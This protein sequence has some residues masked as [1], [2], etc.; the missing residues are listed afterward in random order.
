MGNNANVKNKRLK[1]LGSLASVGVLGA[2]LGAAAMIPSSAA[3]AD[4]A[5]TYQATLNP[6][7][8]DAAGAGGTLSLSLSGSQAT[9][10][11]HVNG[12]AATFNGAPY[13]HVQH[14]HINGQDQCPTA[15]ADTNG[16]GVI[17]IPEGKPAYGEI[18]T[19]LSM[20]GST[21]ESAGDDVTVAPSG[22]S[23]T[24]QRTFTINQAT[25]SAI[26]ANKAVIVV[27]GLNPANAPKSSLS[28]PN[29]DGITLPGAP[30]KVAEVAVA[31]ALCGVLQA[32][33]MTT[34]PSGAADTGNGSS[35]SDNAGL[36]AGGGAALAVAAV[37]GAALAR[38]RRTDS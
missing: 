17:S 26:K 33:Q 3:F 5:T 11:E 22:G 23:F 7:N 9:I 32:S 36:I 30:K 34:I 21:A 24:Y 27:H 14:I 6:L 4:T 8:H 31:P 37:G 12:L 19:T 20:S 16:N 13:P 28:A 18:G 38:R 2:G 29:Q 1:I 25:L 10:T 15:A 35:A